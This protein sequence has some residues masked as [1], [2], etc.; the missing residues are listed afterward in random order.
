MIDF[1]QKPTQPRR[2][3][4][5]GG[6][7]QGI[8]KA[9]APASLRRTVNMG[10]I[11]TLLTIGGPLRTHVAVTRAP[12]WHGRTTGSFKEDPN[13]TQFLWRLGMKR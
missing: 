3:V 8:R 2:R 12:Y 5:G 6:G 9:G 13:W 4:S 1:N 10:W 7:G 11:R